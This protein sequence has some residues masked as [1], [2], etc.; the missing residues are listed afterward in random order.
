M[1]APKTHGSGAEEGRFKRTARLGGWRGQARRA[2]T[3]SGPRPGNVQRVGLDTNVGRDIKNPF[4]ETTFEPGSSPPMEK[5]GR[6]G[7]FGPLGQVGPVGLG[8][9]FGPTGQGRS[10][11]PVGPGGP[12]I[13][14]KQKLE[15]EKVDNFENEKQKL[16]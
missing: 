11:S 16:R 3:A 14:V 5:R 1:A 6:H 9:S 10:S 4:E 12:V 7:R 2:E 15:I 8:K 13:K